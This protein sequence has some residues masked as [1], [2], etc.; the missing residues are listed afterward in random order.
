MEWAPK[1]YWSGLQRAIGVGYNR[2]A[3]LGGRSL[4]LE[5]FGVELAT[6]GLELEP[7]RVVEVVGRWIEAEG[8]SA[9]ESRSFNPPETTG[10]SATFS[11]PRQT[12]P[13]QH[14]KRRKLQ[15]EA[16][17]VAEIRGAACF[18]ASGAVSRAREV[19]LTA[20]LSDGAWIPSY[21]PMLFY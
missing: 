3:R 5:A 9:A 14:S 12:S 20:E 11:A 1:S 17:N 2:S 4:G 18:F 7:F 8:R 10:T 16:D 6:F 15:T 13:A 21:K 19:D